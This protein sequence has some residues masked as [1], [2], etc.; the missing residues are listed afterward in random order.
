MNVYMTLMAVGTSCTAE[1]EA[2]YKTVQIFIAI[3]VY[4]NALVHIAFH[5]DSYVTRKQIVLIVMMS[6]TVKIIHGL[7]C[8]NA[9][10]GH[11]V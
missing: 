7:E 6:Y 8:S 10:T 1:M 2:I 11:T 5:G 4:T 9:R 3:Q